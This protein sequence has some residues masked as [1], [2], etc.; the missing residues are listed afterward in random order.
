M[1]TEKAGSFTLFGRNSNSISRKYARGFFFI[2]ALAFLVFVSSFIN[3]QIVTYRYQQEMDDLLAIH[4][5]YVD[6]GNVHNMSPL[7]SI[8]ALSDIRSAIDKTWQSM[9][10]VYDSLNGNYNREVM[11]LCCMVETY[12]QQTEEVVSFMEYH[13][14]SDSVDLFEVLNHPDFISLRQESLNTKVYIE[15]SFR[16]I[17]KVKML[18][19]EQ[20][21]DSLNTFRLTTNIVQVLIVLSALGSCLLF[22]KQVVNGISK[23]IAELTQFTND[24][25]NNPEL[26]QRVSIQTG[27]EIELFSMAFNEMLDQIQRQIAALEADSQ[28]KE[29]LSAVELEN[30][31]VISALQG[32]ELKFLQSRI[33]PHF[34]F[35]T[36]NMIIQTAVLEGA[37]DTVRLLGTTAELLRYSLSK[38]STPVSM[39]DELEN[40]KNYLMIQQNRF[41]DRLSFHIDVVEDRCL[42]QQIPCMILQPLV[43]NAITHG[44]G[45]KVDGG[46]LYLRIFRKE[47]Q[48]CFEI[49][50]DGV[51]IPPEKLEHI[52]GMCCI[53]GKTSSSSIGIKNVYQRL[54]IFYQQDV[55]FEISSCCG[56]TLIHVELPWLSL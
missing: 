53:G 19:T 37:D 44:I 55:V 10:Q 31:R 11:D 43:E 24:I 14:G 35:N 9:R 34:L 20:T 38:L 56:K 6:V 16:D 32:S 4:K 12:L 30:L 8:E 26:R 48:C 29:Q 36:L 2:S 22:Y 15:D 51:G 28:I 5:I 47:Q 21:H 18:Q 17:Y 46:S 52:R 45:P 42:H 50:D 13:I 3:S 41:G 33:N 7:Y 23:S 49:E 25:R 1:S 54:M 39:A 40:I 27:D